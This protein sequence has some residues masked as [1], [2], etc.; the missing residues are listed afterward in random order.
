MSLTHWKNHPNNSILHY[1]FLRL[2][3]LLLQSPLNHLSFYFPSQ[4]SYSS[5]S[6]IIF[7]CHSIIALMQSFPP[8]FSLPFTFWSFLLF[9][10]LFTLLYFR[11][12]IIDALYFFRSQLKETPFLDMETKI[13]LIYSL[14]Q[15]HFSLLLL[16]ILLLSYVVFWYAF[17]I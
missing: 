2:L 11:S 17:I 12:L 9:L 16:I 5:S 6:L 4:I 10:L 14:I 1:C 3:M 13:S 8:M 7:K 15:W